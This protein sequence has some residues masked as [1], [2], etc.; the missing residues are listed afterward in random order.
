MKATATGSIPVCGASSLRQTRKVALRI[1]AE[2][3]TAATSGT[4]GCSKDWIACAWVGRWLRCGT[5]GTGGGRR[6]GW[7]SWWRNGSRRVATIR[8]P[9]RRCTRIVVVSV[10]VSRRWSTWWRKLPVAISPR[11]RRWTIPMARRGS[12]PLPIPASI[13]LAVVVSASVKLALTVWRARCRNRIPHRPVVWNQCNSAGMNWRGR[14]TPRGG[15]R[16]PT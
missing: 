4:S 11:S 16:I 10:T 5:G 2:A 12:L 1:V 15:C 14:R 9:R 7:T 3:A 8:R 13:T 6:A